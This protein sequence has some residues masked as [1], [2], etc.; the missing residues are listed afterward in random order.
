M[1][2]QLGFDARL[3][4]DT[5]TRRNSSRMRIFYCRLLFTFRQN[6]YCENILCV[7]L[8]ENAPTKDIHM[9]LFLDLARVLVPS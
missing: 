3:A 6:K 1:Q 5:L 9:D 8:H 4:K 7:L 2:I